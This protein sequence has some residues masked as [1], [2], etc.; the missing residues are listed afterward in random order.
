[1]TIKREPGDEELVDP[2]AGFATR[3]TEQCAKVFS[4]EGLAGRVKAAK[5]ARKQED[6]NPFWGADR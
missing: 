1:M 5:E 3:F 2:N 4:E 6:P